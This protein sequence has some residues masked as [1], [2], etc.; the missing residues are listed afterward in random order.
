MASNNI[1]PFIQGSIGYH[2]SRNVNCND[3]RA[4][5][6][7]QIVI[8]NRIIVRII[9]YAVTA[10]QYDPQVRSKELN[11]RVL[12]ELIQWDD[13]VRGAKNAE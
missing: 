2:E 8:T 3:S 10:Y 11:L 5:A 13:A 6:W 9:E 4:S 12:D 7:E 1:G